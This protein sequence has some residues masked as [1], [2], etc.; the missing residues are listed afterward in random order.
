[1]PHGEA[2]GQLDRSQRSARASSSQDGAQLGRA[3]RR[4]GGRR[5]P[6]TSAPLRLSGEAGTD[7]GF[8]GEARQEIGSSARKEVA[9]DGDPIGGRGGRWN[10]GSRNRSSRR[11]GGLPDA[12]LR[13]DSRARA[14]RPAADRGKPA[15][16]NRQGK[17]QARDARCNPRASEG[18]GRPV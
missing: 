14:G 17:G 7:D 5:A 18:G 9:N 3:R 1:A 12:A 16:R 2:V 8:F 15:A 13:R 4:P 11:A 6:R 10:H